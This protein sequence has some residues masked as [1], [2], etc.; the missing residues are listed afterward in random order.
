MNEVAVSP[1]YFET[2]I[3]Y[4]RSLKSLHFRCSLRHVGYHLGYIIQRKDLHSKPVTTPDAVR[5]VATM[6]AVIG[7]LSK[8]INARMSS[9]SDG[10]MSI[11]LVNYQLNQY[12]L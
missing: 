10:S 6:M 7:H 11:F 4:L 12:F 5:M 9:T 1:V 2:A 3:Q 8:L